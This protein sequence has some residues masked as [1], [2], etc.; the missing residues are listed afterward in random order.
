MIR[1]SIQTSDKRSFCDV[2]V[3]A[4]CFLING[5]GQA[6]DLPMLYGDTFISETLDAVVESP[7]GTLLLIGR[8]RSLGYGAAEDLQFL[9]VNSNGPAIWRKTMSLNGKAKYV[10]A[11]ARPDGGAIIG[12]VLRHLDGDPDYGIRELGMDGFLLSVNENADKQWLW[13]KQET[14]TIPLEIDK[15][16]SIWAIAADHRFG[17]QRS[18]LVKFGQTGELLEEIALNLAD[19]FTCYDAIRFSEKGTVLAGTVPDGIQVYEVDEKGAVRW[20]TTTKD[21]WITTSIHLCRTTHSGYLWD[22]VGIV[23]VAACGEDTIV[24]IRISKDGELLSEK[25]TLEGDGQT[26]KA[27][28]ATNDGGVI[29]V[30]D[31][32]SL[33]TDTGTRAALEVI[34][35]DDDMEVIYGETFASS[36]SRY[37]FS[38][39]DITKSKSGGYF[40]AGGRFDSSMGVADMFLT[41][42]DSS[43]KMPWPAGKQQEIPYGLQRSDEAPLT[44]ESW[45]GRIDD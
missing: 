33:G 38:A 16:N 28:A 22:T 36:D 24:T 10:R 14:I 11:V 37:G 43:G 30:A 40:L 19:G 23:A 32:P 6:A 42:V 26:V 13:R 7:D 29:L 25:V 8:S 34:L 12:G 27:V 41:Q 5:C 21:P 9:R 17:K 39:S 35:L 1:L 31:N 3:V 2:I 44:G 15:A 18:W 4:A 20:V 45:N